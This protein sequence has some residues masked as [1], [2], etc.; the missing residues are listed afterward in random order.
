[1]SLFSMN[2]SNGRLTV[3]CYGFPAECQRILYSFKIVLGIHATKV[4]ITTQYLENS[5]YSG[6]HYYTMPREL[7][8]L[9]FTLLHSASGTQGTPVYITKQRLGNSRYPGLHYYTV[10]RELKVLRFTLIHSTS[11]TQGTP[12]YINAQYFRILF[13][14]GLWQYTLLWGF[15]V[16]RLI[17]MG[18][19]VT[20]RVLG[21]LVFHKSD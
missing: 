3:C 7:K 14:S 9:R 4:Y 10:P 2:W 11:R 18:K 13:Y 17:V 8:V 21:T 6:L 16:F 5:R 12:V 15:V 19:H 1:M 20:F